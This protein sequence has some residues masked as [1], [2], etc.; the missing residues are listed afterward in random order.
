VVNIAREHELF[1]EIALQHKNNNDVLGL[2]SKKFSQ[3]IN[4]SR[5]FFNLQIKMN[6]GFDCVFSNPL[7]GTE[8]FFE[9]L[10]AG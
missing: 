5:K 7:I 9:Y 2:V 3:V 6:G 1:K 4:A 8:A 10:G